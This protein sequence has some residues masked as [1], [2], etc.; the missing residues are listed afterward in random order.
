MA[1]SE[2]AAAAD[3]L[4][5]AFG[6]MLA[7]SEI[8]HALGRQLGPEIGKALETRGRTGRAPCASDLDRVVEP[9]ESGVAL[10]NVPGGMPSRGRGVPRSAHPGALMTTA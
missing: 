8:A 4:S 7:G 1:D 5:R 6:E 10:R 3:R 2:A 9:S